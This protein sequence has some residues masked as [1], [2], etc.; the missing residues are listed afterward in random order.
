M[1]KI[2]PFLWFDKQA[3]E[4]VN[5]YVSIFNNTQVGA[6][7]RYPEGPLEGP[8]AGLEGKVLTATF[9]LEGQTFMALDGGPYFTFNPAVSFMVSCS[10]A[11]EVTELFT[12]LADGG[13]ILMPL[14]KY[15]FSEMYGWCNDKYGVSWQISVGPSTQKITPS[16]MFV[17]D[18]FGKVAEA[19]N[20]YTSIF[21]NSKTNVV[22]H[23][24]PGDGDEEGKV[25][26]AS[27]TL[28]GQEFAAMESSLMHKFT[29]NGA[30]SFYIEC[31]DQA[32]VD[33]YWE[34]LSE[35]GNPEAQQC[36]WL[37]DRYGFSWQVI[38]TA[39][40]H[41]LND[42][43]KGRADR[44]MK[45]MLQMKKIDIASLEAAANQT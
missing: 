44:A 12:K 31:A 23:Y 7:K 20:F 45:A 13:S 39:L 10:T 16:L 22:A 32:E 3:E 2:I 43:D 35:G 5:Y 29:A 27:F 19:L 37:Q 30:I 8:M 15:D 41:L 1:Q 21:K 11:D 17:G 24:E 4:A 28:E 42:P 40:P 36:G 25:K 6:I 18:K 33:Y 38:P 34:K 14:Q 26:F 9:E